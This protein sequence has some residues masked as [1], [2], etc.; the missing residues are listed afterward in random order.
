MALLSAAAAPVQR[1]DTLDVA[2]R[3]AR[4]HATARSRSRRAAPVAHDGTDGTDD[5]QRE[6]LQQH[7]PLRAPP[8]IE[9]A[10]RTRLL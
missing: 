9:G 5:G 6:R 1:S 7:Y 2:L 10:R 4:C 3:A 8:V